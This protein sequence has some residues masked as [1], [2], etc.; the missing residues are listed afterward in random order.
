M[1]HQDRP[2][3]LGLPHR[4]AMVPLAAIASGVL[5]GKPLVLLA[6]ILI[7]AGA[8]LLLKDEDSFLGQRVDALSDLLR[9]RSDK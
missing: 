5:S 8:A 9:G 4:R 1:K 7:A 3:F 6:M 2:M